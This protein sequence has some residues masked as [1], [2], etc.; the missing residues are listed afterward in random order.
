MIE[1]HES[2]V[3][4]FVGR[5]AP[6]TIR[7]SAVEMTG[8]PF[9]IDAEEAAILFIEATIG[10]ASEDD[11]EFK[12]EVQH[13]DTEWRRYRVTCRVVRQYSAEEFQ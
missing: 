6:L 1:T 8:E 4:R 9:H 13:S 10:L 11:E 3:C 2:W 5:D 7:S 12:V